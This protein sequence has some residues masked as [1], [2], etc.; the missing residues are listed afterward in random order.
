MVDGREQ[1]TP[2]HIF[3]PPQCGRVSGADRTF[4]APR[5]G[6]GRKETM[7][8]P[9]LAMRCISAGIGSEKLV[10]DEYHVG[11]FFLP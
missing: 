9:T 3:L 8:C 1:Y 5:R 10:G 7:N 2:G 6:G 11:L 4:G